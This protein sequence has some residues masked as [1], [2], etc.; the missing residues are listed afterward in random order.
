MRTILH[1]DLDCFYAQVESKR[2]GLSADVP[3]AVQQ[4][5]GLLAVNYAARG[6]A[7]ESE[8]ADRQLAQTIHDSEMADYALY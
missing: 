1:L 3:L 4:W 8:E 6:L 7:A 5:G 2:L